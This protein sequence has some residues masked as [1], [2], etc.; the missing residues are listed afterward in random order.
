MA[1]SRLCRTCDDFHNL[2]EAWPGACSSHF[3]GKAESAPY[4]RTDGMDPIRSM[5]DGK[6]YD[7][8]SGYYAS[9]RRADCEIVGNDRAGYGPRPEYRPQGVA[10][11]IKTAIEKL[12]AR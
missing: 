11:S 7:S 2:D 9:V 3:G 12:S 6:V 5:A 10:Q 8:K 4:V 1:R